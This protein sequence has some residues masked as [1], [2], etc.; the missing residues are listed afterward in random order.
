MERISRS[1]L[2]AGGRV[3]ENILV[4]WY[5]L[6]AL[7]IRSD[8]IGGAALIAEQVTRL[9][10]GELFDIREARFEGRFGGQ[11]ERVLAYCSAGVVSE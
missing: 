5:D 11:N 2:V 9:A 6:V 10:L 4:G 3:P 8:A 7:E 1:Y